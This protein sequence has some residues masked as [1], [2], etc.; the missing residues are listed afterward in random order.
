M[1]GGG[2]GGRARVVVRAEGR[3]G[4]AAS[5]SF[6]ASPANDSVA[7]LITEFVIVLIE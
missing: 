5:G 1:W 7:S 4:V 2:V 3:G 6:K